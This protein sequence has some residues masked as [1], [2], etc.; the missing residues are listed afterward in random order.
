MQ[1]DD[2]SRHSHFRVLVSVTSLGSGS[3]LK[4]PVIRRRMVGFFSSSAYVLVTVQL[5]VMLRRVRYDTLIQR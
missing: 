2:V 1:V 3:D 4:D 5:E